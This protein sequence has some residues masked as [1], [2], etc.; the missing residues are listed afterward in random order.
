MKNLKDMRV[1]I[2]NTV[3]LLK[4]G[5]LLFGCSL[6]W[7]CN[8]E[9]NISQEKDTEQVNKAKIEIVSFDAFPKELKNKI[10]SLSKTAY[11]GKGATLKKEALN[12]FFK[13]EAT[14]VTSRNGVKTYSLHLKKET[15]IN[16]FLKQEFSNELRGFCKEP[17]QPGHSVIA[18][19]GID[20]PDIKTGNGSNYPSP[21]LINFTIGYPNILITNF[22]NINTNVTTTTYTPTTSS[23]N[24]P[25]KWSINWTFLNNAWTSIV[26]APSHVW[27]GI[28]DASNWIWGIF[29]TKR[30]NGCTGLRKEYDDIDGVTLDP[31][32]PNED[33]GF[34]EK[35]HLMTPNDFEDTFLKQKTDI[36][37]IP[38]PKELFKN[39]GLNKRGAF[40]SNEAFDCAC[41][42]DKPTTISNFLELNTEQTLFLSDNKQQNFRDKICKFVK[43]NKHTDKAKNWGKGQVELEKG[44]KNIPWRASSG[45]LEN[46]P[47]LKFTH[48]HHNFPENISYFKLTDGSIVA[49]S[50]YE[51]TLTSAGDLIDKYRSN[52]GVS[53]DSRYYYIKLSKNELWAELL[54]TP[55][56]LADGLGNLFKLAGV[57]LGKN[58]GRYVLPIEDIKILIDGKDFNG[59]TVSKWKA[60]AGLLLSVAPLVK[61]LDVGAK[62]FVIVNKIVKTEDTW[63]IVVKVGDKT[64][65]RIVRELSEQT[66]KHFDKYAPNTSKLIDDALRNGKYTDD[67]I[68]EAAEIIEDLVIKKKKWYTWK[69]ILALFARGNK[70]N[71]K[72]VAKYG[73]SKSEIVLKDHKRIDTYLHGKAIISRKATSI[74]NIKE[75]TWRNYCNE[76]VTKYKIGK[77][78]NSR[79]FKKQVKLSGKYQLE[80][81]LSNKGAK[82]LEKF[83]K[84]AKEYGKDNKGGIEIIF[85]KE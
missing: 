20:L 4:L 15:N 6:L 38:L 51:K 57:D 5:L 33:V 46:N 11:R 18:F 73:Y 66:L 39:R 56:N 64:Y 19:S 74:D 10:F 16:A 40:I 71:K 47:N 13:P 62:V 80:I 77:L 44:L 78:T 48:L 35:S 53:Q 69:E 50:S 12:R 32:P 3:N 9:I 54:L 29:K 60:S 17:S 63:R 2:K 72:G 76:L 83:K 22:T 1:R 41:D 58:L 30:R 81:P 42:D 67:V 75:A 65:T 36:F 7:N 43:E 23:T 49:S 34:Q 14:I 68:N 37:E 52:T 79:K 70:F 55:D 25:T 61:V 45:L 59:A 82:N 27:G 31:C 21:T 24:T 8:D 28:K 26:S 84:I 85:L